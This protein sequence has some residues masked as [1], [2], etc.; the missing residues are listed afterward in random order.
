MRKRTRLFIGLTICILAAALMIA[1]LTG[2]GWGAAIGMVG[3][4][5]LA[6]AAAAP[7]PAAD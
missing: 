6:S 2:V 7:R 1:D 5:V 3:V 4:G